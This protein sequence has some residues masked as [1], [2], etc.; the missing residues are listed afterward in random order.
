ML[1]NF[2]M[3]VKNIHFYNTF[4]FVKY[5]IHTRITFIYT[6]HKANISSINIV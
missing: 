2:K 6:L 3:K 5:F 1:N 4:S